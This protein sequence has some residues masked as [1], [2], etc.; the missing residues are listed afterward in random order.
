MSDLPLLLVK[1]LS[2]GYRTIKGLQYAVRD[3]NLK[4]SKG[5]CVAI[6]GESGSG[7]TTLV[8]TIVGYLPQNAF[9]EGSIY[10]EGRTIRSDNKVDSD[11][12][13]NRWKYIAL[14][15]QASMNIFNPVITIAS[16]FVDTAE[17]YGVD[18][19][20]ALSRARKLLSVVKLDPDKVLRMYAHQLSGGMKQRVAIALALLLNPKVLI[21]DEPT[22]AL[23]AV[24]QRQI[25]D[26]LKELRRI[27]SIS[28]IIVTHD[29][30][31]ANYL[32]DTI[33]VMY[34]G[35]FVEYGKRSEIITNPMHPYTVSLL[36]SVPTIRSKNPFSEF[37][38]KRGD[39]SSRGC[40]LYYR[41]PFAQNDCIN[42]VNEV[43]ISQTHH[44]FCNHVSEVEVTMY[45]KDY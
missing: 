17:A 41:C 35:R 29:I 4:L 21:L 12:V 15:P 19:S 18:K 10:M 30:T 31:V 40:P 28:M 39:V 14:V 32:A 22:S 6:V 44:V 26:L 8:N 42:T 45:G 38:L 37:T 3:V 43:A 16:H 9:V 5:E 11:F 34:G 36:G 25:L 13:R 27:Y 24:T 2:V 20:E 7:K 33:Y 23:D 1:D